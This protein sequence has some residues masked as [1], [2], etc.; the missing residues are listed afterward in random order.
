MFYDTQTLYKLPPK[1]RDYKERF[2]AKYAPIMMGQQLPTSPD[3]LPVLVRV[4]VLLFLGKQPIRFR[5][6]ATATIS[7]EVLNICMDGMQRSPYFDLVGTVN[8]PI[9]EED[10]FL[11]E[12][13][14]GDNS[15]V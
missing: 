13:G 3:R 12:E 4:R 1:P 15:M 6:G 14:G 11:K 2:R 8:V 10:Y 5:K 9:N 7:D